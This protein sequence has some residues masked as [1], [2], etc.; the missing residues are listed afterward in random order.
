MNEPA[1]T[2]WSWFT[3]RT[4]A[5]ALVFG[6]IAGFPFSGIRYNSFQIKYWLL[7]TAI[8]GLTSLGTAL[9]AFRFSA[10]SFSRREAAEIAWGAG[11]MVGF[12]VGYLLQPT[13]GPV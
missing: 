13:G 4:A 8:I 10:A 2:P 7:M 12:L 3:P 5:L 1:S 11:A 9:V 6:L